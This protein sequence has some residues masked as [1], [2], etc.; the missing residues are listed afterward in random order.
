MP[1][2]AATLAALKEA[3]ADTDITWAFMVACAMLAH[4]R[5]LI[6]KQSALAMLEMSEADYD[7]WR[8]RF[9]SLG[10]TV[11]HDLRRAT[12]KL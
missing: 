6:T 2:T 9:S 11:V 3:T 7:I 8:N 10:R 12:T 5:S 4:H 1:S